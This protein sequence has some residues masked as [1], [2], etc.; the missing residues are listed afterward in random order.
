MSHEDW[1]VIDRQVRWTRRGE[2]PLEILNP[3]KSESNHDL[4]HYQSMY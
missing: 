2:P 4:Y 1:R 3:Q